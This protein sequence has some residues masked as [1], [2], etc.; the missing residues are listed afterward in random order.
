M[1]QPRRN[2]FV[3]LCDQ[4]RSDFLSCYGCAGVPTPNL[5]RLAANGV[6]FD[7]AIAQSPVCGPGRASMMTGR[8][9]SDH[10]VWANDLPE[11]PGLEY[12]P[13]RMANNG[14]TTGAFGKLHHTPGLDTKGFHIGQLF[15]EGR[16][17]DQDHYFQWLKARRPE[18]TGVWNIEN[19]QFAFEPEEYYEHWIAS[20]T[21]DFIDQHAQDEAPMFAWVSFQGP[22]QPYDPP[23]TVVGAC[24]PEKLPPVVNFAPESF[25]HSSLETRSARVLPVFKDKP[26]LDQLRIAYA[27]MI[28][29]IDQQI[30]RVHD[31]LDAAGQLEKTTILFSTDHGDMLGDHGIQ[32]KGPY[33]YRQHLEIPLILSNH[34]GLDAGSR[35][36]TLVGNIDLGATA[37]D[38]AG[39]TRAFGAARSLLGPLGACNAPPRTTNFSEFCDSLKIVE[40][41]R[42]RFG[43]IPF[44]KDIYL[45]EPAEDPEM[46]N[47]LADNPAYA[48]VVREM[49][50]HT[51]D[52]MILAKG[53]GIEAHDL[54][55]DQ[56][57]GLADKHPAYADEMPIVFAMTQD[58]YQR[59]VEAGVDAT[60]NQPFEGKPVR[61]GYQPAYWQQPRDNA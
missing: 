9:V 17:G 35:S 47:N 61:H 8:F 11:R 46:T 24:D 49:L 34:P 29:F 59:T 54:V 30:G 38:I 16:L 45:Y 58:E 3:F 10:G 53:V 60:F 22:H 50:Q 2:V 15:E 1:H 18:I 33:P 52:Y 55:W 6:V 36:Q 43:Y 44:S 28:V 26:A 5:D 27:E 13:Q 20:R 57:R 42:F 12:L 19:G 39:D 23:S 41:D 7:R 31:A 32:E 48:E 56:Q 14:Y 21:I 37:L 40:N 4:L 51:V 25:P